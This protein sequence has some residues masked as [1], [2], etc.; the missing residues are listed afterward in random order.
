[1]SV[2]D[3]FQKGLRRGAEHLPFDPTKAYAYVEHPTEGWRV[4]LRSAAFLHVDLTKKDQFLVFRNSKN[5]KRREKRDMWEPPKGQMEGKD[6]LRHGDTPLVQLL[7]TSLLREV[8]EEAHI[9]DIRD[10]HYTGLVFQSQEDSYPSNHYFQYHIFQVLITPETVEQV[11]GEFAWMKDH[12]KAVARWRRDRRETD[13]VAWFSPKNT[14]LNPRWCPTI[15]FAY[16]KTYDQ[17]QIII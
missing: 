2:F 17:R 15:V 12:P 4:Y 5:K 11:F 16:L 14:P 10:V 6:L 1:M 13:A 8:E 7:T 3:V 9:T